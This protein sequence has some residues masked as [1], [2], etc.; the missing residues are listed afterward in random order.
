MWVSLI[1]WIDRQYD[2]P[3][4]WNARGALGLIALAPWLVIALMGNPIVGVILAGAWSISWTALF[5]WRAATWLRK[6]DRKWE[7]RKRR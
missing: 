7:R 3:G 2:S 4:G 1:N 6:L 5:I